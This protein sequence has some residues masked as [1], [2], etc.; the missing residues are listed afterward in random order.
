MEV[1]PQLVLLEKTLLNV[2]GLGRQLYP[3]LDLWETAQP[4]LEKWMKDQ[5]N[6]LSLACSLKEHGADWILNAPVMAQQVMAGVRQLS[7]HQDKLFSHYVRTEKRR[8]SL[9]QV[10]LVLLLAGLG[11]SVAANPALLSAPV[12]GWL[13]ALTGGWLLLR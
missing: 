8:Q 5:V 11:Y 9:R 2:E 1:Q 10:G 3:D 7:D 6:P 4:Y 12:A 13:V